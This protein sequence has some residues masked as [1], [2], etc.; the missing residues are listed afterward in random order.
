[1]K[2][3][4]NYILFFA[5]LL[6]RTLSFAALN[7]PSLRCLDV[8]A[9]GDVELS[10][11]IPTD[12]T[13]VFDSYQIFH[14]T[15]LSGPYNL[16]ATI[17]VYAQDNWLHIGA[18][19]QTTPGFYYIITVSDA[20]AFQYSIPSDS[21]GTMMLTTLNPL[22]GTA[23][24][25]WNS[26]QMPPLSTSGSYNVLYEYPT[27]I[28]NAAGN[29]FATSFLDTIDICNDQIN[30]RIE[31]SDASGCISVSSIDGDIYQNIIPPDIPELDS[32]SVNP[33]TQNAVIGWQP[34][35]SG[36]TEGYIIY[37][38]T[39]VWM[40]IDTVW[41][42][43]TTTY[44]N[45]SSTADLNYESYCVAAID[46]CATTSPL[47]TGHSTI[48]LNSTV[49]PCNRSVN[50]SWS[51]YSGFP[52]ID[53][54][55]IYYAEN[56]GTWS[57]LDVVSN[58]TVQYEILN[59]EDDSNYCFYISAVSINGETS[60]SNFSCELLN[61]PEL[62]AYVY[63]RYASVIGDGS[64]DVKWV[65]DRNVYVLGYS[66]QRSL[67]PDGPW[68]SIDYKA[69]T[70]TPEYSFSDLNANAHLQS[71][72]Y[73]VA[74]IDSCSNEA[75]YSDTAR[76]IFL[77]GDPLNDL[78]N[79]LRWNDYEGWP[80]GAQEYRLHR[81]IDHVA[82]PA[83]AAN[84]PDGTEYYSDDVASFYM[85][86]GL[87]SYQLECIEAAGNPLGYADTTWSNQIVI[88][89]LPRLFIANAFSPTG[90]NKTF[91]P[92]GVYVDHTA[93]SFIIFNELGEEMFNTTDF[94]ECWD[95]TNDGS[96]APCAVYHYILRMTLPGDLA[97]TKRGHIT[98]LR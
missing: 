23:P 80:A 9:N 25:S 47:T 70:A 36:D 29:T 87:F 52:G 21:L 96:P 85:S 11:V 18:N 5:L 20:P 57:V 66:L 45:T 10:W 16:I 32:V 41:G 1:M 97:F 24:L 89:Q 65:N 98:L 54:Y 31:Q 63:I 67:S 46:S 60:S 74:V 28:W 72:F 35:S 22:N 93:Y 30:F 77:Q 49:D 33:A 73:R 6:W 88:Q 78:S 44:E 64:V 81:M 58:T 61:F 75:M 79:E 69:Y 50:L 59:L 53:N 39:G 40:P 2:T 84:F 4:L 62:P 56:G 34:S 83:S 68:V 95:G 3:W 76:T 91:C 90:Y 7:A 37:L 43:N 13:V 42:I 92:F 94:Y 8:K 71:V 12:P 17:P 48:F 26:L 19:A 86:Y 82:E 27:G 15:A 55:I 38:F 51:A 14:S